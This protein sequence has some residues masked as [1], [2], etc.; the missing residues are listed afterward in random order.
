MALEPLASS[1][2]VTAETTP[3]EANTTPAPVTTITRHEIEQ[4]AATS[5]PDLLATLPGFSLDRTGPEGGETSLFLD[6]GNSNY[7][8]VLV[9]GTPQMILAACLI[10]RISHWTTWKRSKSSMARRALST[11]RTL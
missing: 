3:V 2:V 6:G 4:R 5:L 11:V 9:D 8:K 1:V 7:T 10:F